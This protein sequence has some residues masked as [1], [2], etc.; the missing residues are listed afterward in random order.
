MQSQ[1]GLAIKAENASRKLWKERKNRSKKVRFF[2]LSM[3]LSPLMYLSLSQFRGTQKVKGAEAS[4]K[5]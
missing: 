4:K 1:A 3:V 5:K 2:L